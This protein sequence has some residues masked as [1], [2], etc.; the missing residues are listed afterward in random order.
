MAEPK[1]AHNGVAPALELRSVRFG[2]RKGEPIID[3]ID[4]SLEAKTVTTLIGPNGCGK[5]TALKLMAGMLQPESGAAMIR[6]EDLRWIPSRVRARRIAYLM[7]SP[8]PP[9]MTVRQLVECG[10]FPHRSASGTNR[11]RDEEAIVSALDATDTAILANRD[12]TSLSGGQRQRA[13]LAMALAQETEVLLLDEPTT[14]L[15]VGASHSIMALI[16]RLCESEGKTVI[17]VVHDP[18]LAMR[19]SDNVAVMEHGRLICMGGPGCAETLKAASEAFG[20]AIKQARCEEET[21]FAAFPET[22]GHPQ[23]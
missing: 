14:Y 6:G 17:Q 2:Y 3:G 21:V 1:T 20:I 12:L 5:S 22:H 13:F 10:R 9:A 11:G 8:R 18:D 7:Q 16:R 23:R 15:D 19:Y 4:I